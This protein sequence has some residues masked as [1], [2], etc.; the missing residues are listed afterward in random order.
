MQ[1]IIMA[2]GE[3]KRLRPLTCTMPKPMVPLL[4]KPI[5]DYCVELLHKHGI[6]D[7][8]ATLYYMPDKIRKHLG[9]GGGYGVNMRYSLETQP[10]GTAGSVRSAAGDAPERTIIISGD[11][12][13]DADLSS[14]IRFH[15]SQRAKVTIVLT[16]VEL[17]SEYG[18]VLLGEDLRVLRFFEK[19][20]PG[21][22]YSNLANT[23][24]Y[25]LEP[26][27]IERIPKGRKFDFSK[28]LFPLLLSE[29]EAMYGF[30]MQGYWCDVGSLETYIQAQADLMDGKCDA[31]LPTKGNEGIYIEEGAMLSKE[32][33]LT[34]PCYVCAEAE[35]ASGVRIGPY[36]VIG[37][38]CRIGSYSSVKHSVLMRRARLRE[39]VELRGCI[40]CENVHA[41]SSVSVFDGAAIGGGAW[42][43]SGATIRPGVR[44]WPQR[45]VSEGMVC[46]N[47]VIW[48]NSAPRDISRGYGDMDMTPSYAASISAAFAHILYDKMPSSIAV[49]DDGSQQS[50]MLKSA[51]VSGLLSQGA[52]VCDF[53]YTSLDAFSFAVRENACAGGIYIAAGE[54]AHM[55]AMLLNDNTGTEIDGDM[56]RRLAQALN[57]DLRPVTARRLGILSQS[58]IQHIYTAHLSRCMERT[59]LEGTLVLSAP[60]TVFDTVVRLLCARGV[61]VLLSKAE[62]AEALI[63]DMMCSGAAISCMVK[64][65]EISAMYY[66]RYELDASTRRV[67][68]M[69]DLIKNADRR[70]FLLPVDM[71]EAYAQVLRGHGAQLKRVSASPSKWKKEAIKQGCYDP[72]LFET[73]AEILRLTEL[74]LSGA[75]ERLLSRLPDIN[76]KSERVN[77]SWRDMGRVMRSL[78]ETE[79]LSQAELIEGLRVKRDDGWVLVQ[80]EGIHAYRIIADS[81]RSEYA[82]DLCEIYV[83]KVKAALE[84]EK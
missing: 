81:M 70:S 69:I 65:N 72:V 68:L 3:G 23:G 26:E 41:E 74:A 6:D 61:Q 46:A 33:L 64:N 29:G 20:Q 53:G 40:L 12:L 34:P 52:D 75:L 11:A 56:L 45:R 54:R 51:A 27:I 60:E 18:V 58:N 30:I 44:V 42:L 4:G 10:L 67:V 16:K 5:I 76:V 77:C 57:E 59:S 36:A 2:G 7:V 39:N 24:I 73:E 14:A 80:P 25:I 8:S 43:E 71:P 19:P 17:A 31:K 21:E 82:G 50:V 13:T 47:D 37:K 32:I 35:I 62:K 63:A 38:G 55:T 66:G 15:E 78:V 1:A 48:A 9:D 83:N 79:N 84:T 28:D 22:V 49:A